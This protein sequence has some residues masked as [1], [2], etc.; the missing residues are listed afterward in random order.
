MRT[1]Q[2]TTTTTCTASV[3]RHRPL[4]APRTQHSAP[5]GA[6]IHG[7]DRDGVGRGSDATTKLVGMSRSSRERMSPAARP[8]ATD[9]PHAN[10]RR[11]QV[12]SLSGVPDGIEH[13]T[14]MV[15]TYGALASLVPMAVLGAISAVMLWGSQSTVRGIA[16]FVLAVL[17]CPTLAI[18]GLPIRSGTSAWLI[19]V[20]SS[21]LVWMVLGFVAARRSTLRAVS[22]WPE[23]RRE[24]LRLAV[25]LWA[26][27]FIGFGI[28]GALVLIGL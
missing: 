12:A 1:R 14:Q 16:G 24:W 13:H 20:V 4:H 21:A 23:W 18:A 15:R 11:P 9:T 10:S 28:A 6:Q 5:T 19:A 26:G 2:A 17:A 8:L 27:A 7:A 25:G 22:S 3:A